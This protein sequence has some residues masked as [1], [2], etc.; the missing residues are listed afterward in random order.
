MQQCKRGSLFCRMSQEPTWMVWPKRRTAPFFTGEMRLASD[1]TLPRGRTRLL[2]G[3][4]RSQTEEE[5]VISQAVFLHR[6]CQSQLELIL[7]AATQNESISTANCERPRQR[8]QMLPCD[9]LQL[10]RIK[11]SH[12][13][14][15]LTILPALGRGNT[16]SWSRGRA[17]GRQT[18]G[19]VDRQRY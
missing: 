6:S 17:A 16:S 5:G 14:S 2:L 8:V 3:S 15:S 18:G 11:S 9:F 7:C 19:P 12:K 10:K 1:V 13:S 4:C